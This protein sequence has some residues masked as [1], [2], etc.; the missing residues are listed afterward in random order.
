MSAPFRRAARHR[1]AAT[2]QETE[3]ARRQAEQ[4]RV[5]YDLHFVRWL[6]SL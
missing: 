2:R 1:P 4:V 3:N 6:R 5:P